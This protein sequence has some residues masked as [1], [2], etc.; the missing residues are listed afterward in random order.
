VKVRETLGDGSY[1]TESSFQSLVIITIK[2][3]FS[4]VL[5]LFY[6]N[7]GVITGGSHDIRVDFGD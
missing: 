3:P 4:P 2:W 1:E 5:S 7:A 6:G